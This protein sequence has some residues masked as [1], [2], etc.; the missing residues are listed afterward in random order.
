[1]YKDGLVTERIT[2]RFLVK[3]DAK[4]WLGYISD[5]IA[6]EFMSFDAAMTHE[7]QC[8]WW[9]DMCLKRYEEGRYGLQALIHRE[10]GDLIGMCGLLTQEVSGKTELEVGYHL[11]RKDWG[12][13]FATEAARLFRDYGFQHI[14]VDSIV[15]VI[16]PNN[17]RSKNVAIRNS[18]KLSEKG[19]I[20]RGKEVDVFRI[21]RSEWNTL[22]S[23]Q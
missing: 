1:M 8:N 18:M 13:G 17:F 2:T 6:T 7:Q 16:H 23:A 10:T 4:E 21:T 22:K 3:E 14:D 11:L 9:V 20:F 15:S 12:L 19:S 5:P